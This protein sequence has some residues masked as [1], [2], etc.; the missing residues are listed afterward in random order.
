MLWIGLCIALWAWCLLSLGLPR[1]HDAVLLRSSTPAGRRVLRITGWALLG[2]AFAWF[3]VWKGWE[4]GA[5]FWGAALVLSA[6]A[7]VLLMTLAPRRSLVV[8]TLASIVA[9]GWLLIGAW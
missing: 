7:W 6:M 1:H 5:I 8:P 2:A 3:V 9:T 4:L